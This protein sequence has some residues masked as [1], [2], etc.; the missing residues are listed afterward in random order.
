MGYI[1]QVL[2]QYPHRLESS[3]VV[4]NPRFKGRQLLIGAMR[5]SHEIVMG[6]H[7]ID[8]F[9]QEDN[10]FGPGDGTQNRLGREC[11]IQEIIRSRFSSNGAGELVFEFVGGKVLLPELLAGG[12]DL[13]GL[14]YLVIGPMRKADRNK[15]QK[16]LEFTP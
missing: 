8:G 13:H 4:A 14:A 3:N 12:S 16:F 11:G 15:V 2:W 5:I 1:R 6:K 7:A 10:H 9:A